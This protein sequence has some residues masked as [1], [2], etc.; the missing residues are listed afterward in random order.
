MKP[1]LRRYLSYVLSP[2]AVWYGV[3]VWCRNRMF[4]WGWKERVSSPLTSIGVGNLSAGGTGKTPHGEYLLRLLQAHGHE[5]AFLSRG[6]RR[7]SKGFHLAAEASSLPLNRLVGDEPAMVAQHFPHAMVAVCE[8]RVEGLQ[9]LQHLNPRLTV[10]LDDVYQHRYV[11]PSLMVLLTEYAHPYYE[12]QVLPFGNL[13]EHRSG[14]RRADIIVV[15]K[16]PE[17]LSDEEQH[18][19]RRKLKP[20]SHQRVFFSYLAYGTPRHLYEDAPLEHLPREILLVTGI[21]HP[22]PLFDYLS[23]DAHVQ[24]L[25]YPDHH[26]FSLEELRKAVA[27]LPPGGVMMTTEK[28]AARLQRPECRA[29]LKDTPVYLVPIQVA[30]HATQGPSFD[31]VV[32]TAISKR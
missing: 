12:D 26:D 19:I 22:K 27:L 3:G 20:A 6:Y 11:S 30:F 10:V 28:D 31:E 24:L 2:L 13:R 18:A 29:V 16:C 4:D 5:V 17:H 15:T 7:E 8:K 25:Q 21:A 1:S 32:L 9:R 14:S 23:K